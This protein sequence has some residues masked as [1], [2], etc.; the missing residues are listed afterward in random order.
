MP[1]P[2]IAVELDFDFEDAQDTRPPEPGEPV[3]RALIANADRAERLYIRARMSLADLTQADEAETAADALELARNNRYEVAVIDYGLPGAKGGYELVRQLT[4]TEQRIPHVIVTKDKLS[5]AE[6]VGGLFG[7]EPVVL[8]KPV[9][10][11]KLTALL[12]RV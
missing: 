6:K 12:S 1:P 5:T 11:L 8:E 4:R 3:K 2:D 10:P 7:R 9:H